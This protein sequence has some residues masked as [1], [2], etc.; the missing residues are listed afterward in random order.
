MPDIITRIYIACVL[1][2]N[3]LINILNVHVKLEYT[4]RKRKRI[5]SQARHMEEI[6]VAY[7]GNYGDT[8]CCATSP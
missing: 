7:T 5:Y 2:L 8:S 3:E 6:A 4:S 1:D